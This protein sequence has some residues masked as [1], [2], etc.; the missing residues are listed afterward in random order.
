MKLSEKLL[1]FFM[2]GVSVAFENLMTMLLR[3][4]SM[5]QTCMDF[6]QVIRRL[7]FASNAE[8]STNDI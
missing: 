2:A 8:N 6:Q 7:L 4:A 5:S 1:A 3:N